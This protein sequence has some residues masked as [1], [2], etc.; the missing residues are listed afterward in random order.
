VQGGI[1]S[2]DA[3]EDESTKDILLMDVAPLSLGTET[4]GGVMTVMIKRGTTIPTSKSSKFIQSLC[5]CFMSEF[6]F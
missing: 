1:L 3:A 6:N 5:L 2:G 4:I